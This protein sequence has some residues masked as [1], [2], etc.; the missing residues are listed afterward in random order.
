MK[1]KYYVAGNQPHPH[2]VVIAGNH[3]LTFDD[4]FMQTPT[5]LARFGVDL[6]KVKDFLK[7]QNVEKTEDLLTHCIYLRD[8][9]VTICGVKIYG[10]PW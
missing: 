8:S 10:S 7:S 3:D 5:G 1:Y 2:K 6:Q 9:S 4:Q